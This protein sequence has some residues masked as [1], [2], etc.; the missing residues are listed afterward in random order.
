VGN[1]E[2][3]AEDSGERAVVA[4]FL[5]NYSFLISV[6]PYFNYNDG[7]EGIIPRKLRD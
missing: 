2:K 1:G 6:G 3:G 7:N 5:F 4:I